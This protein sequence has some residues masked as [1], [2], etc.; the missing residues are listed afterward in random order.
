MYFVVFYCFVI[1]LVSTATDFIFVFVYYLVYNI[2]VFSCFLIIC[3]SM[4]GNFRTLSEL[5]SISASGFLTFSFAVA[6]LS[7]AGVPPFVGFF[8]KILIIKSLANSGLVPF[9]ISFLIIVFI[10]LFFYVQNLRFVLVPA[11]VASTAS[12]H[13]ESKTVL[14]SSFLI[15]VVNFFLITGALYMNDLFIFCV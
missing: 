15:V 10:A 14:F 13:S 1:T 5:K 4:H 12:E 2:A 8:T 7:M 6:L 3:R 11:P 9:L